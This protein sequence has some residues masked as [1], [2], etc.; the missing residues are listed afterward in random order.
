MAE[1]PCL[2]ILQELGETG[3][4]VGSRD[5]SGSIRI[6]LGKNRGGSQPGECCGEVQIAERLLKLRQTDLIWGR[7][8]V[9]FV[10]VVALIRVGRTVDLVKNVSEQ[11]R[12]IQRKIQIGDSLS[13]RS[14]NPRDGHEFLL[15]QHVK[16]RPA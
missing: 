1:L 3:D 4:E 11:L 15:V 13:R 14:P 7:M 9:A 6:E 16:A 12:L 5:T 10:D 8:G 2:Q